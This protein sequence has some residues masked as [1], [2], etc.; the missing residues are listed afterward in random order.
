MARAYGTF[1]NGGYN[2]SGKVFANEPRAITT[3]KDVNGKV[4]YD[5]TPVRKRVMSSVDAALLTQ[6]LAGRRH[7]R[8]RHRGRA[9]RPAGRR[10]DRH[11]GELRRRLVRRL[12]AA[13]RDGGLGRV[14]R[15]GCARC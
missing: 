6:L 12:H 15:R 4:V 11:D 7:G 14:S 8:D 9:A 10:Q 1:A 5:N 2:V 13:A 3:I